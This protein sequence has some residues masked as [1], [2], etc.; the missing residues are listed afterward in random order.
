MPPSTAD[1]HA[2]QPPVQL[3]A[4]KLLRRTEFK[5][6]G[7]QLNVLAAAWIQAMTH[8]WF[9]H[10]D[11]DRVVE[12]GQGGQGC[13]LGFFRFKETEI[14]EDGWMVNERTHWWDAS[15]VYGQ[16]ETMV[17]RARTGKE[18]KLWM[19]NVRGRLMRDGE[20]RNLVGDAKNGWLGVALLQEI[21]VREHNMICDQLIEKEG[22]CDDDD[23]FNKARLAV[24][25][26]VAKIHTVDW[27]VELL[28]N[29]TLEVGM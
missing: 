11:G 7:M 29:R 21:F 17:K 3:V 4:G 28:K 15:F 1:D 26:I 20:G 12:L 18:G 2:S 22:L 24:A 13:P 9:G 25:A 14:G 23:I 5:P 10:K 16:N 6:A 27:T 19:E 8:D